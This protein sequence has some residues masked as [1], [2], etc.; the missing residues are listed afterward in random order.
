[1]KI[2]APAAWCRIQNLALASFYETE[3]ENCYETGTGLSTGRCGCGRPGINSGR[4][5]V[6]PS[7]ISTIFKRLVIRQVRS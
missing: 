7:Q 6:T 2:E 4:R 5:A 3:S 1:M